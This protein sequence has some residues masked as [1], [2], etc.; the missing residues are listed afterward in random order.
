MFEVNQQF[1]EKARRQFAGRDRMYWILGGSCSGKSTLS[2]AIVEK[3]GLTL[4]DM[5]AQIYDAF[6]GRYRDD[7][8]PANKAWLSAPNPLEWQLGLSPAEFDAFYRSA[9]AEYLDLL[10]DDL[11]NLPPEQPI[12]IDGGISHPSLAAAILPPEQLACLDISRAYRVA[13]WETAED[14]AMMREWIA[15]LPEPDEKWRTFLRC[16]GQMSAT[17]I[18]EA[19][20]HHIEVFFREENSSVAAL[21]EVIAAHLGLD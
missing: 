19:K 16:D 11:Q 21:A 4:Y 8:H 6:M 3:H 20:A 12:L 5:D 1:V 15:S 10:A 7:R 13:T 17:M 18:R 14:R 2:R 9:S